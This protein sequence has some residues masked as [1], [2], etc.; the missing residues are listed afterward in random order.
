MPV[1]NGRI[2]PGGPF[3]QPQ[4]GDA[5]TAPFLPYQDH[6]PQLLKAALLL[7]GLWFNSAI[8]PEGPKPGSVED[9]GQVRAAQSRQDRTEQPP[10]LALRIPSP[11][12]GEDFGQPKLAVRQSWEPQNATLNLPA[13][14]ATAPFLPTAEEP[15]KQ[16]RQTQPEVTPSKIVLELVFAPFLSKDFSQAR[17]GPYK[18]SDLAPNL[19][20]QV[21]S[22]QAV[23][24]FQ[25][26]DWRLPQQP[27]KLASGHHWFNSAIMPNPDAPPSVIAPF[28][29]G[30]WPY[31]KL[32]PAVREAA[33]QYPLIL[34]PSQAAIAREALAIH[35]ELIA[36][37]RNPESVPSR[38]IL[39]TA[40]T[41][42][43][44]P[45]ELGRA[46]GNRPW[47]AEPVQNLLVSTLAVPRLPFFGQTTPNAPLPKLGDRNWNQNLLENTLGLSIAAPF[48]QYE[49]P[50]RPR[51]QRPAVTLTYTALAL[52]S[53]SEGILPVYGW[54][55]RGHVGGVARDPWQRIGSET[56]SDGHD[57]IG[58]TTATA[59]TGK[60][61]STDDA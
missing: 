45:T 49:W 38:A 17:P 37:A 53:I 52:A 23:L 32:R 10:N 43:F 48:A 39:E 41:F 5:T 22:A 20:V 7:P 14:A 28:G 6:R 4:L 13:V 9:F 54:G 15:R 42:P 51:V 26:L 19:V 57:S 12:A 33:D 47:Q 60:I 8:M 44:T 24:P 25:D 18:Q 2:G 21:V 3:V 35:R 61:G 40:P 36:P 50:L 34:M 58:S 16:I 27:A 1:I 56:A 59:K 55:A 29:S 11:F 46:K 31:Q 30:E